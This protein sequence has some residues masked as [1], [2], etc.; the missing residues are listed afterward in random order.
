MIIIII[1]VDPRPNTRS[2]RVEGHPIHN[3]NFVRSFPI[4]R[5]PGCR[6]TPFRSAFASCVHYTFLSSPVFPY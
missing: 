4:P 1:L 3:P 5:G 6:S 2:H